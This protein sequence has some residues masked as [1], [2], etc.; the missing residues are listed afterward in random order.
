[1]D[2]L[3]EAG[4][5]G[6][7]TYMI[8]GMDS[9]RAPSFIELGQIMQYARKIGALVG[10]HAENGKLIY[11]RMQELKCHLH[12]SG[13]LANIPEIPVFEGMTKLS[14]FHG[15]DM[16]SYYLSRREPAEKDG[17]AL[18]IGLAN[19]TKVKLH[20][21]HLGSGVGAHIIEE[22][23]GRGLDISTETCPHYLTFTHSDFKKYGSLIKTAPVVKE[24]KDRERLWECLENGTIDF[25][26]TDHAPC[27]PAEKDTG[28][29]WT[30]YGGMPGVELMLPF[31]FSE[32][33]KE[34]RITLA[35]LVEITSTAAAKRFGLYPQKGSLS[36]GSDADIVLIDPKKK[37]KVDAAKM[38]SKA[39]W[40]PFHEKQLTGKIIKTILRGEVIFDTEKDVTGAA[41]FGKWVRRS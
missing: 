14:R 25:I 21:V 7:K 20:I 29:A 9:F 34:K 15:D 22:W 23:K 41:G 17:V 11:E 27:Q 30:D 12:E 36:V 24:K 37:W 26:A 33:F 4:V 35:R 1:M 28:S 2:E 18:A 32:G 8:S 3:W 39:K 10:V 16:H 6:F 19:Q 38:H 40:T 13:D 5:V 31:I